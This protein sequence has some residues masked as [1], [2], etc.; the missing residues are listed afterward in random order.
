ME[1][2]NPIP[3]SYS[4]DDADVVAAANG[5]VGHRSM[6]QHSERFKLEVWNVREGVWSVVGNGLSNQ[7]FIEGPE[8]LIVID[9]G[10]CVEEM[11]A[12]LEM[13]REHTSAPIA[14][15]IYTHYHYVSGTKALFETAEVPIWGHSKIASNLSQ[16]GT[17]LSAVG[18][19]GIVHQFGVWLPEEGEDALINVGLGLGYRNKSHAP[20][21][22]GFI[23]P[24][25]TF[26]SPASTTLAGLAVEFTPA[27]SDS[28]DSV[29]IWFPEL[30][31]AAQNI[32]WPAVFNVFAI[33]GE[34]YRD[35]RVLLTGL[36]HLR[37]LGA[38]HLLATH[39]P[40]LSGAEQISSEIEVFRDSI[41]FMWDQTVRG[42]NKGLT[43][44]ELSQFV[45][46]PDCFGRTYFTQQH[47]GLVEHHVKQIHSGLR[48]WFDGDESR[49]FPM[50]PADRARRLIEGFGGRDQVRGEVRKALDELDLRWALE[51]ASWLVHCEVDDAGR[52]DGGSAADRQLLAFVLREAAQRTTSANVRN[53]ALT[54]ALELEGHLDMTRHRVHRFGAGAV[55][56]NPVG[57]FHALRVLVVPERVPTEAVHLAVELEDETAGLVLRNGVA[58]PTD[59]SGADVVVTTNIAT[60]AALMS[61]TAKLS[62][63]LESEAI[64]TDDPGAVVEFF[65]AFDHD[66]LAS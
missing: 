44:D 48:G 4:I 28:D 30:G 42:I 10:E 12:A 64:S 65:S 20:F 59:G 22:P 13:V 56:N 58:V 54:R 11:A 40:P 45:Q 32:L 5:G 24:T 3:D 35:P 31:V 46:L 55:A 36:D 52:A 15:V 2:L 17:E 21:T 49:L 61:G 33:R 19:R 6:I 25:H 27:P 14:A 38:D 53:W 9:T 39:G 60:F 29:T 51:L 57:A 7:S 62:E 66:C 47:Y 63:L 37:S 34:E 50:P 1:P 26:D 18:A 16:F 43:V 8:G 41:Q 23:E